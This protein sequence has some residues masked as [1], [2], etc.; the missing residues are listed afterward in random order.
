MSYTNSPVA[1]VFDLQR[2]AIVQSNEA[3]RAGLEAQ[4]TYAQQFADFGPAK[5][6]NEQ[7]YEVLHTVFDSYFDALE[8]VTPSQQPITDNF[9]TSVDDHLTTVKANHEE[10]IDSLEASVKEGSDERA[11]VLEGLVSL[12]DEQVEIVLDAHEGL[13]AE[14]I[15][16]VEHIEGEF[17]ELEE[18]F[19]GQFE[20]FEAQ[21]AELQ[22]H[23]DEVGSELTEAAEQQVTATTESLTSIEGIGST[24][25]DRLQEQGIETLDVLAAANAE[26]VAE[27]AAVSEDLASEWIEAAKST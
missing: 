9:R 27:A 26:V 12:L 14:T 16:V 13:E 11:A 8:A 2:T 4:Q 6:A 17:A 25:A 5:Q 15:D 20:Q 21:L 3:V 10:M 23:I 22:T 1:A 18:A 19:E 24:Y 7:G